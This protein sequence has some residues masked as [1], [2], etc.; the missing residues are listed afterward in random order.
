MKRELLCMMLGCALIFSGCSNGDLGENFESGIHT[1]QQMTVNFVPEV[2]GEGTG[3]SRAVAS[4]YND[5]AKVTILAYKKGDNG[6]YKLEKSLQEGSA[7]TSL[8]LP[9]GV[10]RFVAFYNIGNQMQL[11]CPENANSWDELVE[12]I[13]LSSLEA[14]PLDVNE[15]FV[16]SKDCSEVNVAEVSEG[17]NTITVSLQLKRVNAR[18]D[19]LVKK[20][21]KNGVEQPYAKGNVFGE[22]PLAQIVTTATAV[23][24]WSWDH[25]QIGESKKSYTDT[26][27]ADNI[28]IG[29]SAAPTVKSEVYKDNNK[30]DIDENKIMKG[31]AYY[32]GVYVLPFV[33]GNTTLDEVNIKLVS[34]SK[35]ADNAPVSRTLKA[36]N[37]KAMQ[38]YVTLIT[39]NIQTDLDDGETP[40]D[41]VNV[42]TPNIQ[43][44]IQ[45][46]TNW[47]GVDYHGDIEI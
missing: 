3:N 30:N 17:N 40:D 20:V 13:T 11:S 2:L 14:S 1:T 8:V 21:N 19:V 7:A 4:S 37:V 33:N 23:G 15:V 44:N 36:T 47:E 34:E 38:N 25:H 39:F 45:V 46:D 26:K 35:D 28:C 32:K 16:T 10:Y 9:V 27:L 6:A 43:Y 12:Q 41:S 31:S 22:E 42:F 18:I 5:P 24:K 29:V